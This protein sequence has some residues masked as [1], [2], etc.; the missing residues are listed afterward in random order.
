MPETPGE[1]SV[2]AP[3]SEYDQHSRNVTEA[4]FPPRSPHNNRDLS[5]SSGTIF[6]SV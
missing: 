3:H 1:P 5:R 2:P 6:A 4:Y